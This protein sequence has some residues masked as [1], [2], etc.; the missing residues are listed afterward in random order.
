MLRKHGL[1][2][3]VQ[4]RQMGGTIE[5]GAAFQQRVIA[6]AV[7]SGVRV[8]A[9]VPIRMLMNMGDL[10]IPYSMNLSV[11]SRDFYQRNL[12]TVEGIVRGYIEGVAALHH[13]KESAL[14]VISRYARLSDPKKAEDLYLGSIAALERVPRVEPEAVL[15][16][17]EFMGKK[18]VA[19]ETFVDNSIMEKVIREGVADK[20]YRKD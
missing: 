20:L 10:G 12:K 17:L 19:L 7:T 8:D 1:D 13:Q 2:G 5:V 14:R 16:I 15:S 18:G 4:V 11:F 9:H 6:G 3:A